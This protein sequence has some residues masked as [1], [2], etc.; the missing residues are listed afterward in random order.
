MKKYIVLV[1]LAI[2]VIALFSNMTYEQQTIVPELTTI[3][4]NKPFEAQLSTLSFTYWGET[5]SVEE[6][7]YFNFVEFL[8]RKTSHF[9]G[10]GLAAT[11][12]YGLYRKLHLRFAVLLAIATIFVIACVDELRQSF[13]PGRTGIFNDVLID[14]SGA[15]FV[16]TVLKIIIALY[17]LATKNRVRI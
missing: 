10:Y 9:F 11:L 8:I 17:K 16:L 15:I 14:T 3:L 7:G 4:E 13:V 12:F 6:R 5:I 2:S 1:F